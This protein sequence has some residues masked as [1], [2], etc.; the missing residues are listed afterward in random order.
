LAVVIGITGGVATGKTTVMQMMAELGAETLSA[1]DVAHEVLAPGTETAEAVA[2]EF[3]AQALKPEGSIDRAKLGDL[4]FRDSEARGRLNAITH[5]R[6]IALLESH[7]EGFRK[8]CG[9]QDRVLAVEIPL[10][11][12]CNLRY[13][14]D[15][16]IV[17]A[18]EQ[19]TQLHRLSRRS[20]LSREE[21]ALRVSAQMP[22]SEKLKIADW[23]VNTDGSEDETRQQV[24]RIW[25]EMA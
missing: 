12:E 22:I 14:V 11:A 1:D 16:V 20:S 15:R 17:V 6:I 23:V 7:I 24:A 13:L 8:R 25:R 2:R 19:E 10:L 3:G 21:A 4:I 9:D 18:A 5:P